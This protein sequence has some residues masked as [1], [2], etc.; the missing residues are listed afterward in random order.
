MAVINMLR[1][2]SL[3]I[4]LAVDRVKSLLDNSDTPIEVHTLGIDEFA[5]RF[6]LKTGKELHIEPMINTEG[7]FSVSLKLKF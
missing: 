2:D 3:N 4:H 7:G 1:L 5:L 6:K